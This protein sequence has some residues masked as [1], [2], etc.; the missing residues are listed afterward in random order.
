MFAMKSQNFTFMDAQKIDMFLMTH[1]SKFPLEQIP[2]IKEKLLATDDSK[3]IYLQSIGYKDPVV[4]LILSLFL[5]TIGVDRFFIGDIGLGIGKLITCGGFGIWTIVDWFL[6]MNAAKKK[7]LQ[8][9]Y[10]VL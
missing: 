2:L 8:K 5:G 6:I 7:N 3:W 4:C 9:I 10:M 1:G